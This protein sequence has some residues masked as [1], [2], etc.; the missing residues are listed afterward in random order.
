MR[1][2]NLV[3]GGLACLLPLEL[4]LLEF[5]LPLLP[6]GPV[7]RVPVGAVDVVE[8]V[9]DVVLVNG[10]EDPSRGGMAEVSVAD[11]RPHVISEDV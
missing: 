2:V 8:L 3:L 9:I 5:G 7:V 1:R 4:L 10:L 6:V 11:A